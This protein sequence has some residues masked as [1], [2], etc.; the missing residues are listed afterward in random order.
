MI[1]LQTFISQVLATGKPV[2]TGQCGELTDLWLVQGFGNHTEYPTAIDY[3]SN[4]VPGFVKSA[5]PQPGALACYN[6]H[7]GY[8]DGH[9]AIYVSNGEVFEQNADPDGSY[10]HIYPRLSTYL[11]GYLISNV[12]ENDMPNAGDVDNVYLL[13]NGRLA[14][15]AEKAVYTGKTWSAGDGLYYGKVIP[16]VKNLQADLANAVAGDYEPAPQLFIKKT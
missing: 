12:E 3:W 6:A 14:T 2:G 15:D 11:L 4:G 8:P 13:F 10:P 1:D 5:T 16:E 9:I 7:P